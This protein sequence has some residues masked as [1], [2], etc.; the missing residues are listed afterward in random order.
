MS[1]GG[2]S[3]AV[4]NIAKLLT[5][6]SWKAVLQPEFKKPYFETLAKVIPSFTPFAPSPHL[7]VLKY[8]ESEKAI[9]NNKIYPPEP[10]IFNA[11]NHASFDKVRVVILGQDPYINYSI[12]LSFSIVFFFPLLFPA[13]AFILF[14]PYLV[15]L[16]LILLIQ[17]VR[18]SN[19]DV[20]LSPAWHYSTAKPKEYFQGISF[21]PFPFFFSIFS[22]FS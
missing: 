16:F 13:L 6:D 22:L 18:P 19:G 10:L 5:E 1:S 8:L 14:I 7:I 20:V 12:Y 2:L 3:D 17:T 11:F 9:K 4:A 15:S 21:P